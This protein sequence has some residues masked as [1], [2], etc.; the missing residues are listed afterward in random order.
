MALKQLQL[1][2]KKLNIEGGMNAGTNTTESNYI[3]DADV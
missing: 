1:P 3:Y 2:Y